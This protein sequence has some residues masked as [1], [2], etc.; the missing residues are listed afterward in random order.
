MYSSIIF[1]FIVITDANYLPRFSWHFMPP[2]TNGLP[3]HLRNTRRCH[4]EKKLIANLIR[5][6]EVKNM[7][8]EEEK[9]ICNM[10]GERRSRGEENSSKSNHESSKKELNY[11]HTS[12]AVVCL[13]AG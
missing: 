7:K 3:F 1:Y 5:T 6:R 4:A 11:I 9:T 13:I 10:Q 8:K 2:H 12:H